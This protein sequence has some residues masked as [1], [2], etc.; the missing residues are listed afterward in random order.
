MRMK[1]Y[2]KLKGLEIVKDQKEFTE[3]VWIRA[4]KVNDSFID[5]PLQETK[6]EDKIQ[7][8]IKLL[9]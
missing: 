5:D 7:I 1:L 4:I 6:E 2:E 3:L 9:D 8:G